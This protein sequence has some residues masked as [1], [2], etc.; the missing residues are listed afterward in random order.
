M[1]KTCGC[2]PTGK[3]IKYQC[4]CGDDCK[5]SVIEFDSEPNAIPYCCGSPMKKK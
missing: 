2:K 4:D 3:P 1:C 5:C